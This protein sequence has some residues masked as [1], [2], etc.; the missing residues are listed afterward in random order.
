MK[1]LNDF[2]EKLK[3]ESLILEEI[4]ELLNNKESAELF[5]ENVK[6][7]D[8]KL[9]LNLVDLLKEYEN[10]N[11]IDYLIKWLKLEEKSQLISSIISLLGKF[12]FDNKLDVL[13]PFLKSEDRRIRANV[14]E[15]I[16]KNI[17][18]DSSKLLI[19][20]LK[21]KDN[22]V[23]ANAAMALWKNKELRGEV[24]KAFAGM[25]ENSDKWMN[26]SAMYAFGELGIED[27]MLYLLEHLQDEDEDICRNAL[28]ALIGY[29]D[30][31]MD[32]EK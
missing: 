4:S 30:K 12:S 7:Q 19:P 15:A 14:V 29:A 11:I 9:K 17:D 3:E 18:K 2:F 13:S 6:K 20:Y 22:R 26:A 1:N 32:K 8:S 23:R 27:F 5:F 24:K 28:I 25:I 31:S 10:E 21:D 16:G